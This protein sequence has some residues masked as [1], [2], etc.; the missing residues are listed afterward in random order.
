V[1][2][3]SRFFP[4]KSVDHLSG[5]IVKWNK[6]N[7]LRLDELSP[8][9]DDDLPPEMETSHLPDGVGRRHGALHA[10]ARSGDVEGSPMPAA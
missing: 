2:I 8:L 1:S 9:G 4:R 5:L 10:A 3:R 6:A 7:I